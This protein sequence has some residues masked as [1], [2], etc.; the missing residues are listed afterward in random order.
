[1]EERDTSS[2]TGGLGRRTF[3]RNLALGSVPL[4]LPSAVLG[5]EV[6]PAPSNRIAMGFIGIGDHGFQMNLKRLVS[7]PD[8]EPVMLCDVDSEYLQR[9]VEYVES[10]RNVKLEKRAITKDWR[11]VIARPDIDAV[12][13]STP[14]HWH[15]PI[16]LAAI[17]AGK[18]VICEK[19]T[20]TIEEGR[21]LCEA[22]R[23]H[24]RVFQAAMEDRALPV[25]H[26]IAELVHN[27]H[28]GKLRHIRMTL[29][30]EP[31]SETPPKSQPPQ[32]PVKA[33]S[34]PPTLDYEM[35][36]GPAP[37]APYQPERVHYRN[38]AG[39]WRYISDYSGGMFTDWGVH[40]G[41]T[42]QWATGTESTGPVAVS[43]KG[44][45]F[46][47]GL[48]DTAYQFQVRYRYAEGF[49]MVVE[50]GGTGLRFE[51]TDGWLEVPRFGRSIQASKPSLLRHATKPNE[52]HLYTDYRGEHRN[53]L[54][55][56]KSR[57]DP[58]F[59]VEALRGVSNVMHIGTIA[60]QLGRPLKWDPGR[61]IFPH[62][63][64]ANTRISREMRAPWTL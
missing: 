47:D 9:A 57:R 46:T 44:H 5:R 21:V 53:F 56:V 52:T 18:D 22:V 40:M 12:M 48:F 45:F 28:I 39:G 51:G 61:E 62:D 7:E 38:P 35:W 6:R 17:R 33:E 14:D 31:W 8:M 41:D 23:G 2:T 64:E 49:E 32:F 11:E 50:S 1:M 13:I 55:C 25:Y 58:Y 34:I 26:R 42:V 16:A 10:A 36:L 15:V 4:I 30:G 20:L 27:G 3:L 43:G 59:S 37:E 54:D 29:P 60:M 63:A 24:G 19:P